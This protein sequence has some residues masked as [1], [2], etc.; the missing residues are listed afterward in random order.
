MT[1]VSVI[2]PTYNRRDMVLRAL[3]SVLQQTRLADEVNVID[4]GSDDGT[5]D[6]IET[7]FPNVILV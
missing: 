2:I 4:D 1:S 7:R 5:A 6:A 3:D